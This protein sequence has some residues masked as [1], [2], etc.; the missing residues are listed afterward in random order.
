MACEAFSHRDEFVSQFRKLQAKLTSWYESHE[1]AIAKAYLTVRDSAILLLIVQNSPAFDQELE[2]SLTDL[3][4]SVAQ[5]E[6]FGLIRLNVL[7]LPTASEESIQSF[8]VSG[9]ANL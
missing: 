2:E 1:Q 9:S 6:E 7:A 8:L 3:D 4:I 5:D